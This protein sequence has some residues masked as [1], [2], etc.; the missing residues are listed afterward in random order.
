VLDR[1]GGSECSF[2]M[3]AERFIIKIDEFHQK[4]MISVIS[5]ERNLNDRNQR[6]AWQYSRKS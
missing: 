6:H 1:R 2:D 5:M 3:Q 4:A